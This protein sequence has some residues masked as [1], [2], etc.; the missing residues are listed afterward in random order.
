MSDREAWRP[1]AGIATLRRR[2]ALLAGIRAFFAARGVLEVETP[3]LS[4]HASTEPH[5]ASFRAAGAAGAGGQRFLHTSPELFM[6]RL[7]AAGS[8]P[9]YQLARVFRAGEV[10]RWHNPE[11][12]LLE[13]Y[14]PGLDEHALMDEVEALLRRL[15]P[16]LAPAGRLS[17]RDAFARHAG[18]DPMRADVATC[19]RAAA[20][21][22]LPPLTGPAHDRDLWLDLIVSHVVGPALGRDGPCFIHDYPASQASLA[23]LRTDAA[24][25]VVAARFE[26]Y[27]QGIE[28][29]N[30]F[31]E[32]TDLQEQRRRMLAENADRQ[33]RGLPVMPI[34]P[35]F[36]AALAHGLPACAGVALGVDR[37]LLCLEGAES[38]DAVMAFADG[39]V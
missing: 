33:V 21:L 9:I 1:G 15:V 22:Q 4:R 39:R 24:G 28:L 12:T 23:R 35:H 37:L 19:R 17:Y 30:G 32:L 27:W 10:G 7:L 18:F 26:L 6:K 38:L 13:W 31:H 20:R 2:A 8:G 36:L 25:T 16:A 3:V 34:D 29:A 5:L 11:Y 14:R